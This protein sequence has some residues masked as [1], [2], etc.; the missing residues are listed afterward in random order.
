VATPSA[1]VPA[2]QGE[3]VTFVCAPGPDKGTSSC[4]SGSLKVGVVKFVSNVSLCASARGSLYLKCGAH[5]C[6]KAVHRH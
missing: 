5:V 1:D 2:Q 3:R 4:G 6:A